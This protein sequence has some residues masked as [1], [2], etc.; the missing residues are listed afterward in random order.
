MRSADVDTIPVMLRPKYVW[1]IHGAEVWGAEFSRSYSWP[2]YST[3]P[4]EV[5]GV[6]VG[7]PEWQVED[8]V[9]VITGISD[10]TGA[11]HLLRCPD[12]IIT[13]SS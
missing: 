3:H 10:S 8:S 1:V 11:V 4:A 9:R 2:A 12:G 6:A 5:Q 7:G 13:S